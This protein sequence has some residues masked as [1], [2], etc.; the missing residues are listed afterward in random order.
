ME[1]KRTAD[2]LR[3]LGYTGVVLEF[4][5]EVLRDKKGVANSN[6]NDT[7][8]EIEAWRKGVKDTVKLAS[9][10]DFVALKYSV[11]GPFC[12]TC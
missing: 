7:E 12:N 3:K 4:A 5:L 8:A 11:N 9:P 10:G 2:N 6:S 1:V